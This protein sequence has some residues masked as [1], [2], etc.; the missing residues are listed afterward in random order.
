MWVYLYDFYKLNFGTIQAPQH[1]DKEWELVDEHDVACNGE[2]HHVGLE[3]LVGLKYA[4]S[5]WDWGYIGLFSFYGTN[6]RAKYIYH[7]QW[8]FQ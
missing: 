3:Y 1:A 7:I 6:V 4:W 8:C 2:N 5:C